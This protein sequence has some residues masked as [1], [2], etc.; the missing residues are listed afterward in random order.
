MSSH[1]MERSKSAIQPPTY[2]NLIT[3]LS[4]DGGGVRGLIPATILTFLEKQLQELDGEEARIADYFDVIAGTSTGGLVTSMLTVPNVED[5]PLFTA[6]DI[7]AFYLEYC[8]RIFPQYTGPFA[9]LRNTV[10]AISGPRYTGRFFRELVKETLGTTRLGHTMTNVVI[11]AFDIKRLQP[12]IFST[13]ELKHTPSLNAYLS[14]ICISTAA[15]PTFLPAHHFQTEYLEGK[16]R[17]FHLIDGCLAANN[18]SLLAISQVTKEILKGNSDFFPIRPTDYTRF[19]VIS[20]GTGSTKYQ[21]KYNAKKA[22]KWGVLGWLVSGGSTPLV[23]AFTEASAD[24]VDLH[25]AVVFKALH[26]ENNYLRIHDDTLTGALSSVD[27]ATKKNLKDLVNIGEGLLQKPVSRINMDT[28]IFEPS[29]TEGT[30]EQALKRFAK[31]LSS[32]RRLR[33]M[34]SPHPSA[35]KFKKHP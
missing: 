14:D 33:E 31:L 19:L 1:Q 34:R 4:I 16:T 2:G 5:R 15:A 27:I 13:Y 11:P 20:L 3:I 25:L 7:K 9:G 29:K 18:P 10:K 32:E 8:P 21:E 23:D 26:S 28:G 24:M 6:E 22:S 35:F 12:T 30:N 17:E